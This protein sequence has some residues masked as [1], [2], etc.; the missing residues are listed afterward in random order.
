[1]SSGQQDLSNLPYQVEIA[2]GRSN[3]F[4]PK[5]ILKVLNTN[6]D[7]AKGRTKCN[8]FFKLT[9]VDFDD[10]TAILSKL[11]DCNE[12]ILTTTRLNHASTDKFVTMLSQFK[13]IKKYVFHFEQT[14]QNKEHEYFLSKIFTLH[15]EI[16]EL[17]GIKFDTELKDALF[18]DALLSNTTLKS[19]SFNSLTLI[20]KA[21]N[22]FA[23]YIKTSKSLATFEVTSSKVTNIFLF[24]DALETSHITGLCFSDVNIGL[25]TSLMFADKISKNEYLEFVSFHNCNIDD[26]GTEVLASAAKELCLAI[27]NNPNICTFDIT[28]N[29]ISEAAK[30]EIGLILPDIFKGGEIVLLKRTKQVNSKKGSSSKKEIITTKG[31]DESMYYEFMALYKASNTYKNLYCLLPEFQQIIG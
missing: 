29:Q 21:T 17:N 31:N 24:A 30:R 15:A 19:L 10:V 2:Y 4:L 8:C 18:K 9:D 16:I 5:E 11:P 22:V 27:R 28:G 6:P 14:Y 26:G 23:E 12:I 13:N 1:M 3:K 7:E 20:E 25:Q